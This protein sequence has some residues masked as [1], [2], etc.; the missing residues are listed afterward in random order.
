[1][2]I[3][4]FT[5]HDGNHVAINIDKI[6]TVSKALED[7]RNFYMDNHATVVNTRI[8]VQGDNLEWYVLETYDEIM[9]DVFLR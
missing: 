7:K 9:E 5:L 6:A 3:V 1:M 4:E 2:K 8:S